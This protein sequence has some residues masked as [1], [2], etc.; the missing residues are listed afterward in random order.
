MVS[1]SD[2]TKLMLSIGYNATK[3]RNNL[4]HIYQFFLKFGSNE[5]S[6]LEFLMVLNDQIA[7]HKQQ[8]QLEASN[9]DSTV[10][11]VLLNLY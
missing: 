1:V 6:D 11:Q 8:V 9:M 7:E 10:L 4:K 2:F 3:L 5:M